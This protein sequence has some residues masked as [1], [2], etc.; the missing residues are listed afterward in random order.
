M[1]IQAL[2]L[3]PASVLAP[4]DYTSLIWGSLMGVLIF[5]ETLEPTT[6]AGA[7]VIAGAGLFIYLRERQ[8]AR[9]IQADDA[10]PP[11]GA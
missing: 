11:T 6:L 7:A 8:L 3:A 10:L 4:L 2:S 9:Q 5:N 1:L